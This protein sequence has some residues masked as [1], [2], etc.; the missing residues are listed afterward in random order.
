MK[1]HPL[2]ITLIALSLMAGCKKEPKLPIEVSK[3]TNK[4]DSEVAIKWLNLQRNMIWSTP[5]F[6]PPVAARTLGYTSLTLY[7]SVLPG[8]PDHQ[9]FIQK[10]ES[11]P[12]LPSI[13]I[14]EEYYWPSSANA[15]FAEIMRGMFKNAVGAKLNRIDSLE[16]ALKAKFNIEATADILTRS[17]EFGKSIGDAIYQWSK[18]DGGDSGYLRNFPATYAPPTGDG[19]WVQTGANIALQPYWGNNRPFRQESI[20][21]SAL[22]PPLPFSTSENSEFYKEAVEVYNIVKN[23]KPEEI[24]IAKFWSDDPG[25]SPTPAGHSFS[26]MSQV[27]IQKNASLALSAEAFSKLGV[28]LNDAFICCWRDKYKYNLLRPVSFINRYI[29]PNWKTILPTPPFPEYASGHSVESA[30]SATIMASFFGD[31]FSFE[32]RTYDVKGFKPRSFKR[33]S[34]FA[35][36][37]AVSRLYGGIHFRRGIAE[38]LKEGNRI[39]TNY[40]N[41]KLK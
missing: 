7:E 22:L 8:M 41:I 39:G 36:E 25:Q 38:G 31:E 17:E 14:S 16:N 33:F 19:M 9:S 18:T 29:D 1:K 15:A 3:N 21:N 2:L 20:T 26:I 5:G 32:D 37:A 27:L 34:D 4:F 10:L 13:K 35:K 23:I 40:S 30:A 6:S 28:A 11:S 24:E 12:S